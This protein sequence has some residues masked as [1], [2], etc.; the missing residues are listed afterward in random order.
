MPDYFA[1]LDQPRRPWLEAEALK[2][3]FL[4]LSSQIHPDRV[5]GGTE[6][7]RQAAHHRFAE[8]NAAHACLREPCDRLRHLLELE[9]GEKPVELHEI[10]A[11][12]AGLFMKIAA[13]CR[14]ADHFL[15][16]QA[17]VTSPL[18]RVQLFE[19]GH[20]WSGKLTALR[21]E[22]AARQDQLLSAL[23]S[24]DADWT[25]APIDPVARANSVRELEKIY[26][27]LGFF[28]RWYSQLQERVNLLMF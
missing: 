7:E 1:L 27:L 24:L 25:E 26:R 3:Q 21:N 15:M 2:Q 23:K 22:I 19:L 18:L 4:S 10:P 12:L 13:T 20:D 9:L 8:L 6:A 28:G 16:E 5:H 14:E 11:D 17:K